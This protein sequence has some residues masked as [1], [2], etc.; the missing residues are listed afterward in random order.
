MTLQL[1]KRPNLTTPRNREKA[2][3]LIKLA[4]ELELYGGR[5]ISA[6]ELTKKLGNQC[7]PLGAYLRKGLIREG[8]YS[9]DE[10]IAYKYTANKEFVNELRLVLE[11]NETPKVETAKQH[12]KLFL[13]CARSDSKRSGHRFYPWWANMNSEKRKQLFI[14]QYGAYYEYDIE[15]ARPSILLQVYDKILSPALKRVSDRHQLSTWRAYVADRQQFR[16][17]LATDLGVEIEDVKDLLQGVTNGAWASTSPRNPF[18]KKLGVIKVHQ[19]MQHELY[20]GLRKDINTMWSVLFKN[21][22]KNQVGK[23]LYACYEPIEDKIMEFVEHWLKQ[24]QIDAWFVHDAFF[25]HQPV[26][27]TELEQYVLDCTQ[28]RISFASGREGA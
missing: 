22:P 5:Q 16:R 2:L 18:C 11:L 17:H 13:P 15:V 1:A 4:E 6:K 27:T 20:L 23:K 21:Q 3:N 28:F 26:D 8:R 19:F 14:E 7:K 25:C 24:N 9:V 10:G 12:Q